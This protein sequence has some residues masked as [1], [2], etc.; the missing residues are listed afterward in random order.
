MTNFS[1]RKILKSG[2][3]L[4]GG[5]CLAQNRLALGGSTREPHF[6]LQL[7]YSG[8]FD[9]SYLFD[10]RPLSFTAAGKI[11][12][13]L[14]QDPTPWLGAN[15]QSCLASSL[16]AP[17]IPFKDQ[18]SI[19]N[20]VLFP[21]RDDGHDQNRNV[22]FTGNS[23][24]GDSYLPLLNEMLTPRGS[25]DFFVSGSLYVTLANG[26]SSISLSPDGVASFSKLVRNSKSLSAQ[27]QTLD[28]VRSRLQLGS[29]GPGRFSDGARSMLAGLN[30]SFSVGNKFKNLE[31]QFE[32][33]DTPIMKELKC[34]HKLFMSGIANNFVISDNSKD[35]DTHD[36]DSAAKQP[37]SYQAIV[38][39]IAE[40]FSF[41]KSTVFDEAKGLSL[42][43]VT[44]VVIASEFN[45][46]NYQ[47]GMSMDKTG[48]DHNSLSNMMLIGGK[49][50][51]GGQV[52][53]AT[54]LDVL[55]DKGIYQNVSKAHLDFDPE[56]IKRMA[57]PF[58]FESMRPSSETQEDFNADQYLTMASVANTILEMYGC[59]QSTYWANTRNSGK[60]KILPGLLA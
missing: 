7:Y 15:G 32:P 2:A 37:A 12:N 39:E 8:G 40:T 25:L 33:S 26:M 20:G 60:A 50:I 13:Y 17:L 22:L 16:V 52:I 55:N 46:T 4:T 41:L 23:F 38:A 28:F 48:T 14:G 29:Q 10:A 45:R 27:D 31:L 11:Q 30:D 35:L 1:R 43:D 42:L 18:F 49:G 56:G 9:S 53:G 59:D 57:K 47:V 58:N 36:G 51:R 44:T 24:G 34:A 3:A 21:S 19:L 54:D 6:Y 5:L